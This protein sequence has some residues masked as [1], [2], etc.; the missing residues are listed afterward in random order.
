MPIQNAFMSLLFQAIYK[1]AAWMNPS[2]VT[3]TSFIPL[4]I[5]SVYK[6]RF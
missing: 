5:Y 3:I 4:Y 2:E 6:N 1:D